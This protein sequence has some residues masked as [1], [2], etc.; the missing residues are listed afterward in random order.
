MRMMRDTGK[1]VRSN[2]KFAK[3]LCKSPEAMP[4]QVKRLLRDPAMEELGTRLW[5]MV[6]ELWDLVQEE[7][8][9][10]VA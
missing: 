3:N 5:N 2:L 6:E 10:K 9:Q 1:Y 8:D 4:D 7:H